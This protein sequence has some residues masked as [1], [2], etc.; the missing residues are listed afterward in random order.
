L[1]KKIKTKNK[2]TLGCKP[3]YQLKRDQDGYVHTPYGAISEQVWRVLTGTNE[4]AGLPKYEDIPH[5]AE[6]R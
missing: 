4:G 3:P 1:T 5:M 2:K 6:K